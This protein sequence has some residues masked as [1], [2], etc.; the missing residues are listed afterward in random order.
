MNKDIQPSSFIKNSIFFIILILLTFY[1]LFRDNNLYDILMIIK[2]ADKLYIIIAILCIFIYVVCEAANFWTVLNVFKYKKKFFSVLKYPFVGFFF[3][4][5]TPSCTGGQPM[6]L[7]FMSKD[8]IKVAHGTMAI[9]LEFAGFQ[10]A[11]I[12]FAM[13]SFTVNFKFIAT[14][15][16]IIRIL[17]ILGIVINSLMLAIMLCIIFSR[18]FSS[19]N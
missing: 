11:T 1:I 13:I 18:K 4:S 8:N 7:Y 16:I 14:L 15:P 6:Q 10:I 3:S 17:I 12:T 2:T 9:F 19:K 5:I